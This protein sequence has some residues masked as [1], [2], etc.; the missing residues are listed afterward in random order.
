MTN[1]HMK[2][3]STPLIFREMHIKTINTMRY[4]LTLVRMT[5]KNSTNNN[6][7][8]TTDQI[9][10][11]HWI[12][13]NAREFQKNICFTAYAMKPM[14]AYVYAKAFDLWI[15]KNCGKFLKRWK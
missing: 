13:E 15:T 2:R 8:G 5:L 9:A 12:T 11:I 7:R 3:C 4:H 6:S 14:P 10:N 1:G